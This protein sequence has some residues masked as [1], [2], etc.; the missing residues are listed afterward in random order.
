VGFLEKT[1]FLTLKERKNGEWPFAIPVAREK[2]EEKNKRLR[3]HL[4]KVTM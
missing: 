2:K 1:D 3:E 4:H